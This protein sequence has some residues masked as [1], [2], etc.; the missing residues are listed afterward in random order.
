MCANVITNTPTTLGII[1]K[2]SSG[3]STTED[4]PKPEGKPSFDPPD[5]IQWSKT[6]SYKLVIRDRSSIYP[7]HEV[8]II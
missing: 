8:A 5:S 6:Q 4:A 7:A 3:L 2:K 1:G